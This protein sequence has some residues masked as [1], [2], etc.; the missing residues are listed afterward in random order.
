MRRL[1]C[2]CV[3]GGVLGTGLG[4]SWSQDRM[5][6]ARRPPSEFAPS[7]AKPR[8]SYYAELFGGAQE[9]A[10]TDVAAE[11]PRQSEPD[12][13]P[14]SVSESS[15]QINPARGSL[16]VSGRSKSPEPAPNRGVIYA[17]FERNP[18]T[19]EPS[20]IVQVRGQRI[21]R[22]ARQTR[23]EES[24][25]TEPI[26][27]PTQAESEDVAP[28]FDMTPEAPQADVAPELPVEATEPEL[29]PPAPPRSA[30]RHVAPTRNAAGREVAPPAVS[31]ATSSESQAP[32]IRVAWHKQ[33]EVSVGREC[34]C[35]LE[36]ENVG[37]AAAQNLEVVALFS[38]NVRVLSSE[39]APARTDD[40]LVWEIAE[41]S[42]AG[43]QSIQITMLPLGP[44]EITTQAEVRFSTAISGSFQ[45]AEPKLA[46]KLSGPKQTML[47]ESAT[48]TILITNPGTGVA[49]NVQIAARIPNGLEHARGGELLME[50]GALHPG[51]S[52]SVRLPLAAIAGGKHIVQ[53]HAQADGGLVEQASCAVTVVAAEMT[54]GIQGPSLRYL[55]R[56]ATYSIVVTNDGTVPSENVR[57]MH[58]VPEAFGFVNAD[59]GGQFDSGTQLLSWFVGRIDPGQSLELGATFEC[60]EIG[61]FTHFVRATNDQGAVSD[62]NVTTAIE[63]T[64]LLSMSV[65][66]LDDPVETGAETAYEVEIKNE[67]SAVAKRIQLTCEL[68]Q[69]LTLLDVTAP[70]AH[71]E[72]AGVIAFAPIEL[73]RPGESKT[74]RVKVRAEKAGSIRFR[75]QLSSDSVDEP[76]VEEELTKFYAE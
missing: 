67:G 40:C 57:V 52:R 71:R 42:A 35:E 53:V 41:L 20:D 72:A 61:E 65:K 46:L 31:E 60:K 30:A 64:P 55:G 27:I 68:P 38:P 76:L 3:V 28:L 62:S 73:L 8:K 32:N 63:G 56:R 33:G 75:T 34:R 39:P 45:V 2:W 37:A 4:A 17:E 36:L 10:T 74:V 14:A 47:G 50:I 18:T 58:K 70:T 49:A 59:H 15:I 21:V 44:G 29:D 5:P 23:V 22:P 43:K 51:E 24:A 54:T 19:E 25:L 13:E 66:D 12:V 16:N 1:I 48:Q 9:T 69:S 26:A 7:S 11:P 6:F